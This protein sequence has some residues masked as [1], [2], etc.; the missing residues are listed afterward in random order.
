MKRDYCNLKTTCLENLHRSGPAAHS[1]IVEGE[2][3]LCLPASQAIF[4]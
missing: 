3:K 2:I 4:E 1:S